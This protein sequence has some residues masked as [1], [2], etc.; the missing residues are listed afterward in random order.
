MLYSTF[1]HNH[2]SLSEPFGLSALEAAQ[3]NIPAVISKQSGV[4]DGSGYPDGLVGEEIPIHARIVAIADSYDAMN[5]R[6]LYRN[7]LSPEAIREEFLKNRGRQFDPEL[8]DLFLR[9]MRL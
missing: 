2:T 6:H 8:T 1:C 4:Y 7:S 3:F 9:L 5:T